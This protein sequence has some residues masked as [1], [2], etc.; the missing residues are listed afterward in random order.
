M[1]NFGGPMMGGYGGGGLFGLLGILTWLVWLTV[2][3][4]LIMYLWRKVNKRD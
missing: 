1:M 4:L 3:I 2:G